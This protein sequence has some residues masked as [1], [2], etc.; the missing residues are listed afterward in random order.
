M[1]R[2]SITRASDGRRIASGTEIDTRPGDVWLLTGRVVW[3]AS[4]RGLKVGEALEAEVTVGDAFF[5][6]TGTV[7]AAGLGPDGSPR[8]LELTGKAEALGDVVLDI[9]GG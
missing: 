5:L 8:T 2:W 1:T 3:G 9:R 4:V 7:T 6:L